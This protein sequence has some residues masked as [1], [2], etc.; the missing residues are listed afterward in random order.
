MK[1]KSLFLLQFCFCIYLH[2]AHAQDLTDLK[3]GKITMSDF[4][5]QDNTPDSGASAIILS[6]IGKRTFEK[7]ETGD[8]DILFKRFTRVKIVNHNGLNAGEFTLRLSTLVPYHNIIIRLPTEGLISLEGT[9][10][11]RVNGSIQSVK[12]DQ[13][14]VISQPEG[15][16]WVTVKFAM[17]ALRE[18]SIFDVEY[19]SR[20]TF[21]IHNLDWSFQ[22][23]YPCLWSEYDLSLPDAYLYSVKYQGDSS[24]FIHTV[25]A[26]YHEAV[27][28]QFQGKLLLSHFKWVKKN[29]P[30]LT[31]EPY[32]SSLKNYEDKV[33]L[34]HQWR[35]RSFTTYKFYT[36]DT[37]EG[38]SH[39]YYILE[40]IEDFEDDKFGWM[41]KDLQQLTAGL[42]TKREISFAIFKYVRDHFSCT[43]HNDYFLSQR[44]KETFRDKSGNVADLNL[45]LTAMLKQMHI[46]AYP[47]LLTTLDKGVGSL[48]F[49]LPNDYNYLICV[50]VLDGMQVPLDASQRLNPYGKLPAYCYN[51]GA[52]TLDTKKARLISL[53][54]DSLEEQNR[55]NV[56]MSSDDN[57]ILSGN[58]TLN[59]SSQMSYEL[60][61]D[62]K[63][64]SLDRYLNAKIKNRVS[65]FSNEEIEA[66]QDPDKLL[67]IGCDVDFADSIKSDLCYINPVVY[68]YFDRNPF[69]AI[70][71]KYIVEMPYRMD[72]IY[73]LSL[74]IPKGYTVDEMPA[75]GRIKLNDKD[76]YFEYIL[77]KNGDII[78]LQMRMKI[79]KT[80]FTPGEYGNLREFFS[81]IVKK[82]NEQIVFRKI[83]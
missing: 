79:N 17:P 73:L 7:N 3:P 59:C 62:I 1:N 39:I 54:P 10:Y 52:V 16:N 77:E 68:S 28:P 22:H 66:L 8:Y 31:P 24:F 6:D 29:E 64:T 83:R 82:E 47:A 26:A 50:A 20:C 56:I 19:S 14:N 12:L 40:G 44:L 11:N 38:F 80:F 27:D 57:G 61:E 69:I 15:K 36:S 60:R 51:G 5:I 13:A 75:S 63:K 81:Q 37:W 33:S 46:E 4:D 30:A 53:M 74:D 42:Q 65:R 49:P 48:S 76:G 43:S 58:V 45:L 67:T 41:K 34:E 72:N 55:I 18:G 35:L 21:I 71:R 32:I 78:Q 70:K 2:T 9:T 25:E 23:K